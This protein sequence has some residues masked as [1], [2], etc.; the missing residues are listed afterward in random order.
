MNV[1]KKYKSTSPTINCL[2]IVNGIKP[3]NPAGAPI[4]VKIPIRS[5]SLKPSI[6]SNDASP[7]SGIAIIAKIAKAWNKRLSGFNQLI[8]IPIN[9][10]IV[11]GIVCQLKI[12]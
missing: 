2:A 5:N 8:N 4:I 1:F 6:A 9:E 11:N 12:M 7:V 10:P 3:S